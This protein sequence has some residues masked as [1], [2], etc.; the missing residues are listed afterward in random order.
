MHRRII[1]RVGPSSRSGQVDIQAHPGKRRRSTRSAILGTAT[2]ASASTQASAIPQHRRVSVYPIIILQRSKQGVQFHPTL[3]LTFLSF[4]PKWRREPC[5]YWLM[6]FDTNAPV[7]KS[8]NDRLRADPRVIKWTAL[9]LGDKLD[10]ITPKATSGGLDSN[11]DAPEARAL[12]GGKT[13]RYGWQ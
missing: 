6:H 1:G 7:L 8:L 4:S 10:Q 13:M 3:T 11:S 5:S 12:F 9:K 2:T